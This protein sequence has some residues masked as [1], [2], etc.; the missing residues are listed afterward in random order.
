MRDISIYLSLSTYFSAEN[1]PGFAHWTRVQSQEEQAHAMLIYDFMVERGERVILRPIE[2]PPNSFESPLAAIKAAY[3]QEV[4]VTG[5][6]QNISRVAKEHKDQ[7]LVSYMNWFVEEQVQ[8]KAATQAL[9]Y[10]LN[11]VGN[12]KSNLSQMD[13]ELSTRIFDKPV[14]TMDKDNKE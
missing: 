13:K 7:E 4:I 1:L 9:I 2:A 5:L 6:I 8:E 3:E 10:K 12:N 14:I 11:L